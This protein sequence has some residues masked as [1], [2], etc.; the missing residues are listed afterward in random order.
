M[1]RVRVIAGCLWLL[2][3][4][5]P[6]ALCDEPA[7][8]PGEADVA[9]SR[10]MAHF[11]AGRLEQAVTDDL[12]AVELR[13]HHAR[14]WTGLGVV[15]QRLGYPDEVADALDRAQPYTQDDPELEQII[16]ENRTALTPPPAATDPGG[17]PPGQGAGADSSGQPPRDPAAQPPPARF[18]DSG[19]NGMYGLVHWHKWGAIGIYVGATLAAFLLVHFFMVWK[20]G[21]PFSKSESETHVGVSC[22]I[23]GAVFFVFWGWE[24]WVA[25]AMVSWLGGATL[26]G[27]GTK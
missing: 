7:P 4:A 18:V 2:S 8:T 15:L 25:L 5:A 26:S 19:L 16:E 1:R 10:A 12:V 3:V 9:Y 6:A 22:L 21:T 14:A 23:V 11:E 17:A 13:P 24:H 27:I 20:W